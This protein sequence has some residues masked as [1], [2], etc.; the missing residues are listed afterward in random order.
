M[1]WELNVSYR[2]RPTNLMFYPHKRLYFVA[3]Y[4]KCWRL[5]PD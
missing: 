1:G 5:Q 4:D 3:G 2:F